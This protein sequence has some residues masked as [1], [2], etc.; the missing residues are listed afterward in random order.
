MTKFN[1]IEFTRH[2]HVTR[3]LGHHDIERSRDP[4]NFSELRTQAQRAEYMDVYC[5]SGDSS[6]IALIKPP[7]SAALHP[8][9]RGLIH[10]KTLC[11]LCLCGEN[12]QLTLRPLRLCGE[13]FS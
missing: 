1:R 10:K 6:M 4:V 13:L 3:P 11:S 12:N 8:G 9:Y 7:D 2:I 5:K